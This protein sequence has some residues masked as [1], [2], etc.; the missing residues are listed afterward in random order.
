MHL[1]NLPKEVAKEFV[2][3]I[4]IQEGTI[5][6]HYEEKELFTK[7]L[8]HV[9]MFEVESGEQFF[10]IERDN[11]LNVH[12]YHSSPGTGTR[13]AS[14][15]ISLLY[16]SPNV[17]IILSWSPEL[18]RLSIGGKGK[19]KKLIEEE[20]KVSNKQFRI[21]NDGQVLQIGD[22]NLEISHFELYKN[23]KPYLQ[24][25]AI[26]TWKKTYDAINLLIS[27]ESKSEDVRFNMV[28]SN[29]AIVMMVSGY[30]SYCKRRF[31]ET[32][33]EGKHADFKTLFT[34]FSSK[35][36]RENNVLETIVFE[37]KELSISPTKY[38]V[39]NNRIDFQNYENCKKAYK[40]AYNIS[41]SE[42]LDLD[43]VIIVKIQKLIRFRHRIVHY[44]IFEGLFN[45]H[46]HNAKP[47]FTTKDFAIESLNEINC[48]ISQLHKETL[49]KQ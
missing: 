38:M 13:V 26:E 24:P 17:L 5:A 14:V 16:D 25:T 12:F 32:E 28:V 30:E 9:I 6:I 27:G 21:G 47:I 48:F 45:I 2:E 4:K 3:K 1:S 15:N 11:E 18:T 39:K 44:S 7:N 22:H 49:R 46:E 40:K 19:Y 8:G 42:D 41:F 34:H 43:N 20:G 10:R 23:G 29:M 35:S 31:I 36:E 33:G 37:A